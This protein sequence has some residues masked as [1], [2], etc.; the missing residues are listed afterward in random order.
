MR[1]KKKTD[2]RSGVMG[3]DKGEMNEERENERREEKKRGEAS[4]N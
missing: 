4:R 3:W 1:E 2:D